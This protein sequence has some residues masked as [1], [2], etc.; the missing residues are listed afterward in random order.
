MAL[1]EIWIHAN[2]GTIW[3]V[4]DNTRLQLVASGGVSQNNIINALI[5]L[6]A[7]DRR[8]TFFPPQTI[9]AMEGL[10]NIT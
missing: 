1:G 3:H 8:A 6:G 10:K 4:A 5:Q 9:Y 7:T 2:S